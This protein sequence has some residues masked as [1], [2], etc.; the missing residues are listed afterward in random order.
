MSPFP[1]AATCAA[2]TSS[3]ERDMTASFL[4]GRRATRTSNPTQVLNDN[5]PLD[6]RR[7]IVRVSADDSIRTNSA[8]EQVSSPGRRSFREGCLSGTMRWTPDHP[9][10]DRGHPTAARVIRPV[11]PTN[12]LRARPPRK[13]SRTTSRRS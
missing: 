3:F 10:C 8:G 4:T 7:R 5:G 1:T 11:R 6:R 9:R 12:E 13:S 2:K